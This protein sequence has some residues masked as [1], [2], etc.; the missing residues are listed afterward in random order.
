MACACCALCAV[1]V[2]CAGSATGSGR[3]YDRGTVG[4]NT[5]EGALR[6]GGPAGKPRCTLIA[7]FLSR[8][9]RDRTGNVQ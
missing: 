7:F 1:C 4:Y 9:L 3:G 8:P 6:R 5:G 2:S